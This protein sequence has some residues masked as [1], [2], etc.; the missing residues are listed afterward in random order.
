[1]VETIVMSQCEIMNGQILEIYLFF[2]FVLA[3]LQ[4][5]TKFNGGKKKNNNINTNK[6]KNKTKERVQYKL[7][8]QT[9]TIT[10][11]VEKAG[12]LRFVTLWKLL[13]VSLRVLMTI[14]LLRSTIRLLTQEIVSSCLSIIF[15]IASL[16]FPRPVYVCL[17]ELISVNN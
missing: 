5:T 7:K 3:S 17:S 9:Q 15:P 16:F 13:L 6:N 4:T 10:H 8:E 2:F 14:H 11:L 1:M 12:L